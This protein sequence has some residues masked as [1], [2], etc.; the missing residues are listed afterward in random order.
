MTR[1]SAIRPDADSAHPAALWLAAFTPPSPQTVSRTATSMIVR[2]IDLASIEVGG[3]LRAL[4]PAWVAVLAGEIG[5]GGQT[6]PIR[7]VERGTGF[8]LIDG[9]RRVAALRTL[10]SATVQAS[11]EPESALADA[12][13]V[14]LGE[15]K[16]NF[17]RGELT[18]LEKS[19]Y[20]AAW[21]EVYLSVG[22]LPKRG[23]GAARENSFQRNKIS[24]ASNDDALDGFV[25]SL[26]EAAQQALKISQATLSRY[27]R[28]ASIAPEQGHRLTG[29][30]SADSRVELMILA[31]QD[32]VRQRA[33]LD[34]VLGD[35]AEIGTVADAIAHLDGAAPA[36][37]LSPPERVHQV[38]ARLR[39]PEQDAFFAL[40]ADAIERWLASRPQ[41]SRKGANLKSVA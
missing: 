33:I 12:A 4:D 10:G 39:P 20:V 27:L 18:L 38:F 15:I 3:R 30:P 23:R 35:D 25:L 11:I 13:F 40:N 34:L 37:K 2:E 1:P 28:I 6:T 19:Y 41:P 24:D 29:H 8:V 21:R 36:P 26:S 32:A 9:A 14:R 22:T 7:V 17:L 31:E 16:G 5:A